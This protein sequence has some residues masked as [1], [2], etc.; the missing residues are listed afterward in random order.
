MSLSLPFR[1]R[2]SAP[3]VPA[4]E[5]VYAIGDIHGRMDRFHRLL[6]LLHEDEKRRGP[7][8]THIVVVGD[9]IDRG[10]Q[11]AKVVSTLEW[12]QRN[13]RRV[14]IL[15]GNH[16]AALLES[17][18]GDAH[19]QR[20]WLSYGGLDTLRSLGVEPRKG[21]SSNE[22]AALIRS[23]IPEPTIAWLEQL[24][25]SHRI[26]GYFFCHAGVRPGVP[27]EQQRPEHLLWGAEEFLE[28]RRDHGATVVH[29]H[30]ICGSRVHFTP[31][32]I[33]I[34]TGAYCTGILSAVGLEDHRQWS[35]CTPPEPVWPS[36]GASGNDRKRNSSPSPGKGW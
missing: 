27:L 29:G 20:L 19:A 32:R 24:P 5:R 12:W 33:C 23:S 34:D 8:T 14:T 9:F 1:R 15:K 35:V 30:T 13:S 36:V 4:G 22:I 6:E 21:C 10:P 31:N 28:S 26:G 11:S 16:E 3:S 17:L 25:I 7:A 2:R 18:A